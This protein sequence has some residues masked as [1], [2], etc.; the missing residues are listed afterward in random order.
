MPKSVVINGVTYP[1]V[2]YL[3]IPATDNTTATFYDD[4]DAD[5]T[6][7]DVLAGK[8]FYHGGKKTG[9]MINNGTTG[10]DI[11]TKDGTVSIP[12]GYTSGGS[13]GLSSS[14]KAAIVSGNIKSGATILGIAGDSMVVDTTITSDAASAATVFSGKKA[15]INGSLVTGAA[16]VPLVSQDST[17]HVLTI[18]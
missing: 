6:V 11:S 12:A 16:T 14:A 17:T 1:S 9:S 3:E 4:S 18:Q 8:T 10:G 13:V 7:G 15:Y 2:P 5:A